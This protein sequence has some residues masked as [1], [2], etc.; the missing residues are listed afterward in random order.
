MSEVIRISALYKS[1]A[2]QLLASLFIGTH[3]LPPD[4]T[5]RVFLCFKAVW[6]SWL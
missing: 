4:T 2:N 5:A 3:L 6:Q 1:V